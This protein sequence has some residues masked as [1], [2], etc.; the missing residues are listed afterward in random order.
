MVSTN[1]DDERSTD[2]ANYAKPASGNRRRR[3]HD[4]QFSVVAMVEKISA[5]ES[6]QFFEKRAASAST[7]AAQAAW[8]RLGN[9]A[10]FA[11]D[12]TT[13]PAGKRATKG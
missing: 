3:Y 13:K 12:N 2:I 10:P 1:G 8:N 11:G 9:K 4:E 6:A 5:M 7:P